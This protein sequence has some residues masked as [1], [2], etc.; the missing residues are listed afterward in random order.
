MKSKHI[1]I[2]LFLA[3]ISLFNNA[4]AQEI[5]LDQDD[6]KYNYN[7]A[8]LTN[9]C[10]VYDPYEKVNRKLFIVNAVLDGFIL[11][12][13][14]KGYGKVTN[15]YTKDRVE[16]FI[17]NLREP[18]STVNY[19]LQ[20]NS[21]GTFK[22]F[23]RFTI[24]STFGLLGFFDVAAKVGLTAEPQTFG[25]TLARYGVGAGPY[26]VVPFY[27][28]TNARDFLDVIIL[29]NALNPVQYPLHKDFTNIVTATRTVHFRERLM[30]FTDYISQNSPDPYI[31]IRNAI[32]NEREDKMLYP[33]DYVCGVNKF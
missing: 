11:R 12:P 21:T 23:W 30:P 5:D 1:K 16:S 24:N 33:E 13:I 14:A 28:G 29:N 8:Q 4:L 2:T 3:V 19:G 22:T 32:Y 15:A 7:Y 9:R 31:A 6:K 17:N 27:G 10:P 26:L 25:S 20:G 18:L